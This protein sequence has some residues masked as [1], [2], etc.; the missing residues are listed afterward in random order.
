MRRESAGSCGS[1]EGEERGRG[2][3]WRCGRG[4][5]WRCGRHGVELTAAKAEIGGVASSSRR[6]GRQIA[7]TA[8][9]RAFE[10]KE[11]GNGRWWQLGVE[12]FCRAVKPARSVTGIGLAME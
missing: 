6:S 9:P 4:A 10:M 11:R 1:E 12:S 2:E 7:A 5:D 8:W 3:D